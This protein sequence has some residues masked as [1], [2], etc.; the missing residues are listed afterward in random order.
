MTPREL[1]QQGRLA[2]AIAALNEE[3]KANP[4]DAER[5]T[6]LF[7]LLSFTGDWDRAE[8]QLELIA[9]QNEQRE[10]AAQVYSNIVHAERQRSRILTQGGTPEFFLDAPPAI[11][12]LLEAVAT[13]AAGRSADAASLIEKVEQQRTA[14]QGGAGELK[15][16]DFRDCDD[17]LAPVLELIV[18]RDYVWV[19]IEQVRALEV[20][21]P[22]HLRDLIWAPVRLELSD[23]S[24]HRGFM[25]TRYLASSASADEQIQLGR[26]S[27]W[28]QQDGIVRGVGMRVFL[29][30]EEGLPALEARSV[31]MSPA[32]SE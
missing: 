13:L 8:K 4:V 1:Y 3:L 15:F 22:E 31:T 21:D 18:M 11:N 9:R 29:A 23:G 28:V 27:D 30:G 25:P 12:R 6:F 7:E 20:S 17:L 14:M 10:W 16:N 32:A 19:P 2:D 24:S 26:L 5:R